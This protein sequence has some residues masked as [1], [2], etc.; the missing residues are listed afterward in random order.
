M[1]RTRGSNA[2]WCGCCANL[3]EYCF[4][5]SVTQTLINGN[6][7]IIDQSKLQSRTPSEPELMSSHSLCKYWWFSILLPINNIICDKSCSLKCKNTS[8]SLCA[9]LLYLPMCSWAFC[10]AP[11]LSAF[12]NQK[13]LSGPVWS[14]LSFVG[15]WVHFQA[16]TWKSHISILLL[17]MG[18]LEQG[19]PDPGLEGRCPACSLTIL[20]LKLFTG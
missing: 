19:S 20:P 5:E 16:A 15:V 13:T 14:E 12:K 2:L 8:S 11:A 9:P 3:R 17:G 1:Q 6:K 10:D 18:A 7:W 4:S